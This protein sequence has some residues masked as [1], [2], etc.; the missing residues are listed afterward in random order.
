MFTPENA[1]FLALAIYAAAS[2]AGIGGMLLRLAWLRRLG[3]GLA[4]LAFVCQT[5]SLALGFHSLFPAGLSL[6]AYLQLLA[7][8]VMLCGATVCFRLRQDATLI[9]AATLA[10]LLFAMSAPWLSA[11]IAMPQGL[12]APFYALH[13]GSLY[14]SL[15]LLTLAFFAALF[16]LF[17]EARIKS[18]QRMTGFW[19]DLPALDLVDKVNAVATNLAF[20]L[21]TLGIVSGLLWAGSVYGTSLAT[22]PKGVTSIA[23][24]IMLAILF[25]NRLA[26]GWRGRKP[27]RLTVTIFLLSLFS[28]LVVNTFMTSHHTFVRG[29]A[30]GL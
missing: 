8:F 28:F 4:I 17:L 15:A 7:W 11:V 25:H 23:V 24:W 12:S 3:F 19:R 20:P 14:L 6:G 18:K 2:L 1:T 10:L 22:D 13:I 5:G 29:A 16:F 26:R 21:Y 30:S 27:A 9:F